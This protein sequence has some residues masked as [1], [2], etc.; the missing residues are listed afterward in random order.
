MNK[1]PVTK[2][3]LT[4]HQLEVTEIFYTIQ[5]EGPW[6]G[7]P[8]IFIRLAGCNL[9]CTW[10]DTEYDSRNI[11]DE[12]QVVNEVLSLMAHKRIKCRRIVIT[13]GEPFGQNITPLVDVLWEAGFMIQIETNGTL[14]IPAFPFGKVTV[15]CSPKAGR[16]HQDILLHCKNFKY[17]IGKDDLGSPNGL[18]MNPTQPGGKRPPP[19]HPV[20]K[21][22]V[23]TW[24][25][26]RD[27]HDGKDTN[28]IACAVIAMEHG[29][30][31]CL[32][33]HKIL[34]LD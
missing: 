4:K 8:A 13:G 14:T 6:Q 3:D 23:T 5:G 28:A 17:V 20:Y 19:Q 1:Q 32:Q 7:Y 21:G 16:L 9:Q 25:M 26:P 29:H 11:M 18:P 27:D 30:R 10:C 15:V 2:Q 12:A 22:D 31:L 33:Q 34:G 24:L